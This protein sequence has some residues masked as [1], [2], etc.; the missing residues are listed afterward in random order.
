MAADY[1]AYEAALKEVWTSDRL[2]KQ[3]YD[4]NPTLQKLEKGSAQH[5]IGDKAIVPVHT[6]RS[7][8][9][10]VVP[11]TGSQALNPADE[12]KIAQ[13]Q[14]TWTYHWF[15]IGIEKSTVDE[16][17]GKS[18]AVANVIDTEVN[19]ALSDAQK[20]VTR[21]FLG[22]N[23][24]ALICKCGTTTA[25]ATVVLNASAGEKGAQAIV[26]GWL[27]PGLTIDIGTTA[28]EDEVVAGATITAVNDD[29]ANSYATPTITIDSAVTTTSSHYISV[30]NARAGTTSYEANG[31][32]NL[33]GTSTLAGLD[34]ATYPGWKGTVNTTAQDL[35]LPVLYSMGR[36][37]H[38]KAGKKGNWALTSLKQE[39]NLYKQLQAQVRFTGDSGLDAGNVEKVKFAGMEIDSDPDVLDGEWYALTKEDIFLLRDGG[40]EWVTKEFGGNILQWQQGT[41]RL[42]GA[43]NWNINF[44]VRRRNSHAAYLNFN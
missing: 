16:T 5:T 12:Q 25:S 36:T 43:L 3:F 19:G 10:S 29:E 17:K 32:R 37:T 2:E 13:A 18:N 14:Y 23:G 8:G 34:P 41:T 20:Q 39:E 28:D 1:T 22:G 6:G 21:Q 15:Q 31:L 7:G 35:S 26:R 27:Y 33:I 4:K 40:P 38:Q 11:R 44:A 24:D 9:Y 30:A 42:V